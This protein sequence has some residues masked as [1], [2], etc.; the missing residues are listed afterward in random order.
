M[1]KA[2]LQT[3]R[4]PH[5]IAK[6]R[7]VAKVWQFV[8]NNSHSL[9]SERMCRIIGELADVMDAPRQAELQEARETAAKCRTELAKKTEECSALKREIKS[10]KLKYEQDEDEPAPKGKSKKRG[11]H[12]KHSAKPVPIE[13]SFL[14]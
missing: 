10:L 14:G 7:I 12:E 4:T 8:R 2:P 11:R 5:D 9:E 6:E 13:T 3:N 1:A